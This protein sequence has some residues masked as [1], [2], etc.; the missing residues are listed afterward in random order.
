[1]ALPQMEFKLPSNGTIYDLEEVALRTWTVEEEKILFSS[2]ADAMDRVLAKCIVSPKGFGINDLNDLILEDKTYLLF[3][4]RMVSLGEDYSFS[5]K[6]P[7]CG[8][9]NHLSQNM[10]NL[11][12]DFLT[13]EMYEKRRV[14]LTNEDELELKYLTGHD[15]KQIQSLSKKDKKRFTALEGDPSYIYTLAM[16][17]HTINGEEMKI[18]DKADYVKTLIAKDTNIIFN[19]IND[20]SPGIDLTIYD[21]CTSCGEDIEVDIPVGAAFFR[22]SLR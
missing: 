18:R 4:L 19:A 11:P 2:T 14:V 17:I 7:H 16:R 10:S 5:V 22:P 13:E 9:I 20:M 12:I 6:C 3:G 8:N 21:P 1:M 15:M